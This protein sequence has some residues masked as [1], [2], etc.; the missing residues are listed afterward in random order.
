MG[1]EKDHKLWPQCGFTLSYGSK[2][3]GIWN[4]LYFIAVMDSKLDSRLESS[5]RIGSQ[6]R[7]SI[8]LSGDHGDSVGKCCDISDTSLFH[9]LDLNPSVKS[10]SP[11]ICSWPRRSLSFEVSLDLDPSTNPGVNQAN[12]KM[13]TYLSCLAV[14]AILLYD[15]KNTNTISLL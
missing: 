9:T 4:T 10:P 5:L 2:K 1:H 8:F 7:K 13:G 12:L 11:I 3:F 6:T 15:S 14:C